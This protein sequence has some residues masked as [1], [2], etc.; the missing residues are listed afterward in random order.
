MKLKRLNEIISHEITASLKNII[1]QILIHIV[2]DFL[3]LNELTL[4]SVSVSFQ[5]IQNKTFSFQESRQTKV[6]KPLSDSANLIVGWDTQAVKQWL[7]RIGLL[8]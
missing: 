7:E 4:L 6:L 5:M 8:K 3:R 2:P 1:K